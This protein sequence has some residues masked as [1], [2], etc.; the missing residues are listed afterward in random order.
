MWRD[1]II[2]ARF[3]CSGRLLI[4]HLDS[5]HSQDAAGPARSMGWAQRYPSSPFHGT[6]PESPATLAPVH[7]PCDIAMDRCPRSVDG[8]GDVP[9][10]DRTEMDVIDV[11]LHVATSRV[12][13]RR[14]RL[15]V[16]KQV[17]PGILARW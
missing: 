9:V 6:V 10:L 7:Q 1:P 13:S 12:M 15:T 17:A 4:E 3:G 8:T 14:A 16:N 2:L 11:L 5:Q